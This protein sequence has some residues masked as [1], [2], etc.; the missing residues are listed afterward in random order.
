MH[1]LPLNYAGLALIVVAIILFILE[2]KITSHGILGIGGIVALALGSIMLIKTSSALEFIRISLNVIIL[3]T[4]VS[5]LFFA[6]LISMAMKAQKLKPVTGVEGM[7]GEEGE[8]LHN[9]DPSGMVS[10]HGELWNARAD[11]GRIERGQKITVTAIDNLTL[12]VRASGNST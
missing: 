9:L 11:A 6:F 1:T 8:A 10:V 12:H 3:T 4:V 7:I 2:V 5:T